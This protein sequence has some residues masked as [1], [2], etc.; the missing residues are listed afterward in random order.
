MKVIKAFNLVSRG[1][2][3]RI[4]LLRDFKPKCT[5]LCHVEHSAFAPGFDS[6]PNDKTRHHFRVATI[7][8]ASL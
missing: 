3:R 1:K 8:F 5:A 4:Y 2:F 7:T 6:A